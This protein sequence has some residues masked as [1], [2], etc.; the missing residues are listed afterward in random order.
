MGWIFQCSVYESVLDGFSSSVQ[1]CVYP[2]VFII[3]LCPIFYSWFN[4]F[5]FMIK[6]NET[7][8]FHTSFYSIKHFYEKKLQTSSI[9]RDH[10]SHKYDD[11]I[12]ICQSHVWK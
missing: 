4:N 2:A 1:V 12:M 5:K 7:I 11:S 3:W 6:T 10:L 9:R 8:H